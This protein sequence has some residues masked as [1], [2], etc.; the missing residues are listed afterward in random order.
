MLN[1]FPHTFTVTNLKY[2]IIPRLINQGM[3]KRIIVGFNRKFGENDNQKGKALYDCLKITQRGRKY[4]EHLGTTA[5]L[6]E[7]RYYY[8][9]QLTHWDYQVEERLKRTVMTD[10]MFNPYRIVSTLP[11]SLLLKRS[12]HLSVFKE[13][14]QNDKF[15][16]IPSIVCKRTDLSAEL[17]KGYLFKN[18]MPNKQGKSITS[19]K[20][21]GLI[22]KGNTVVPVYNAGQY[23]VSISENN[24]KTLTNKIFSSLGTQCTRCVYLYQSANRIRMM[25]EQGYTESIWQKN[26]YI[27][28]VGPYQEIYLIPYGRYKTE[29]CVLDMIGAQPLS[30][31]YQN[32]NCFEHQNFIMN[33]IY[34]QDSIKNSGGIFNSETDEYNCYVGFVPELRKLISIFRYYNDIGMYKQKP[35]CVI[36]EKEQEEFFNT[37]FKKL[38]DKNKL[39]IITT[40]FIKE[41]EV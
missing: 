32:H 34:V 37:I 8:Q 21:Y 14:K 31:Y 35:L 12:P 20:F 17:I 2:K 36:C 11:S 13:L 29:S 10:M 16:Y 7:L 28:S 38:R 5:E 19:S 4:I 24:E 15:N 40:N 30:Q 23:N 22:L 9:A 41:G 3:V 33:K 27:T 39:K 25:I 26:Q 1:N 6:E 18:E